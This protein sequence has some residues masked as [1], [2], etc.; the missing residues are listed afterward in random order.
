MDGLTDRAIERLER[1]AD[2]YEVTLSGVTVRVTPSGQKILFV[3]TRVGGREHRERLGTWPECSAAAALARL[4]ALTQAAGKPA[5]GKPAKPAAPK[6]PKEVLTVAKFA[7][8]FLREHVH[9]FCKPKT[10]ANYELWL[11]QHI[12][13]ILGS[14]PLAAVTRADVQRMHRL[15]AAKVDPRTGQPLKTTANRTL[16]VLSSLFGRAVDWEVVERSPV[17]KIRKF[18]ERKIERY[19][20]DEERARIEAV[21]VG[22]DARNPGAVL[23]IRLLILTGAR[24]NE[25]LNLRWTDVDWQHKLLRLRDTKTGDRDIPASTEVLRLLKET[26]RR[27]E[28]VCCTILGHK[29]HSL[30]RTWSILRQRAG[31]ADVRKHDL[32]HNFASTGASAGIP[33]ATVGKLLGHKDVRTTQR[34]AHLFDQEV[35]AAVEEISQRLATPRAMPTGGSG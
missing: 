8:R 28:L 13:P 6:P 12:L 29:I 35:R 5:A 34:Y 15:V 26:E 23:A 20:T 32:R 19:L 24:T 4:R 17:Q 2:R 27:G 16:T 14:L 9:V 22:H 11:G 21:L 33:L 3:R 1:R 31:L 7:E 30:Q 25:I 18:A 10:R